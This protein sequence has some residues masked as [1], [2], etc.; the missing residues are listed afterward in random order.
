MKSLL[1]KLVVITLI[2]SSLNSFAVHHQHKTYGGKDRFTKIKKA[3]ALRLNAK[4][5]LKIKNIIALRHQGKHT[6][7]LSD[8]IPLK[9]SLM[10]SAAQKKGRELF[11]SKQ[12]K[13]KEPSRTRNL[14]ILRK[15]NG[16]TIHS[17]IKKMKTSHHKHYRNGYN[18]KLVR[19]YLESRILKDKKHLFRPFQNKKFTK[20]SQIY[21]EAN[22]SKFKRM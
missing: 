10:L 19:R 11:L 7:T 15:H 12:E 3:E 9:L 2:F 21:D 14:Y 5:M 13:P 1:S 17:N 6:K 8:I 22:Y 4:R 20:K 16:M 18:K